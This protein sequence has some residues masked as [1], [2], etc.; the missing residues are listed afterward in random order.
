MMLM[1]FD[2]MSMRT[3]SVY[4]IV[5]HVAIKTDTLRNKISKRKKVAQA[6]CVPLGGYFNIQDDRVKMKMSAATSI[7]NFGHKYDASSSCAVSAYPT[8]IGT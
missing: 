7:P 5:E 8:V 1:Y 3:I 2:V 6:F 4:T